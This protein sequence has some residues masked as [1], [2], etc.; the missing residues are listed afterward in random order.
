MTF[1][2]IVSSLL[3]VVTCSVVSVLFSVDLGNREQAPKTTVDKV[4]TLNNLI[5]FIN[6]ITPKL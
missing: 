4:K 3:A 6:K 2:L 5:L 1:S